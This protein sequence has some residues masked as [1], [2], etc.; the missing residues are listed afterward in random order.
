MNANTTAAKQQYHIFPKEKYITFALANISLQ[1]KTVHVFNCN[2]RAH[3]SAVNARKAMRE[4]PIAVTAR[5]NIGRR[6]ILGR[7]AHLLE[8]EPVCKNEV[9]HEFF[10]L[11][12]KK[13]PNSFRFFR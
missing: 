9:E 1:L 10:A 5:A 3:G 2:S 8:N 11:G 12:L 6:N 7:N 4:K 13:T